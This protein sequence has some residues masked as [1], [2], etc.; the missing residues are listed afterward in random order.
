MRSV[1]LALVL[2]VMVV[3]P[4]AAQKAT[5]EPH[6]PYPGEVAFASRIFD[7][8]G[9]RLVG[10]IRLSFS[11]IEFE[12]E[13]AAI[14]GMQASEDRW[15]T[16][17]SDDG[18]TVTMQEA[19]APSLGDA[20]KAMAGTITGADGIEIAVATL[21]VRIGSVVLGSVGG[22]LVA[23]ALPELVRIAE[24]LEVRNREVNGDVSNYLPVL[25]DMPTGFVVYSETTH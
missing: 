21:Q 12:N 19:S 11:A 6:V 9:L 25:A 5:P 18:A 22:G 7:A 17:A 16:N 4:A 15:L 23:D 24:T 3:A 1:V 20:S 2:L 8:S 13:D 14:A 10:I